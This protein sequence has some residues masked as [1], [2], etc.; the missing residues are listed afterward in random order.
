[1]V[2][3]ISI[4]S[5]RKKRR[6]VRHAQTHYC[7]QGESENFLLPEEADEERDLGRLARWLFERQVRVIGLPVLVVAVC[8]EI[9]VETERSSGQHLLFHL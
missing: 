2:Y 9:D 6:Y 4:L 3:W 8:R 1:M 7:T 5:I